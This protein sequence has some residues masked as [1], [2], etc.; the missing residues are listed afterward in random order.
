MKFFK[1]IITIAVT[2][3]TLA[4]MSIPCSAADDAFKNLF[5]NAAY[6]GLA[7]TLVGGALTVFTEKPSDHADYVYYG[8]AVGVL[9]GAAYGMF[10]TTKS[11]VTIENGNV[12]LAMPTIVPELQEANV[13]S[14]TLKAELLRGS[15]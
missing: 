3:A 14:I 2:L 10:K 1:Q 6:G 5:E 11:L 7:G 13:K 9:A 4:G 8:A 15:F 12:K